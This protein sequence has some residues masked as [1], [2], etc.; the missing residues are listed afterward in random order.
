MSSNLKAHLPLDKTVK[1]LADHCLLL[2]IIFWFSL[3]I[4][5]ALCK[6]HISK[7]SQRKFPSKRKGD[8][9]TKDNLN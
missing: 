4:L 9:K 2:K 5:L 8:V 3:S 1:Y 6:A 7:S